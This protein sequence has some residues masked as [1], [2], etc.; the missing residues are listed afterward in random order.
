MKS[1]G[2]LA[3]TRVA[4]LAGCHSAKRKV[5][6]LIPG[7]GT[8]LG[9]GFGPQLEWHTRGNRLT[10]LSL[11]FSLPFPFSKKRKV[12]V[13]CFV[14]IVYSSIEEMICKR[15]SFFLLLKQ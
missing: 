3:L 14:S 7:Q 15:V 6:G 2:V 13:F 8:C 12:W 9:C 1:I 4:Q 10:S 11:S 5:T